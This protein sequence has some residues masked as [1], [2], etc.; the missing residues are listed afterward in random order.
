[1]VIKMAVQGH[2]DGPPEGQHRVPRGCGGEMVLT[3]KSHY[4]VNWAAMFLALSAQR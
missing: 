3:V 1:M 2:H 4:E